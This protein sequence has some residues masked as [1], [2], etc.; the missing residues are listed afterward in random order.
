MRALG[1][2]REPEFSPGK[3]DAD[4]AILDA[5]LAQLANRGW[6]TSSTDPKKLLATELPGRAD[7]VLAMCQSQTA[8]EALQRIEKSGVVVINA[9]D[10]IRNCYRIALSQSLEAAGIPA[11]ESCSVLTHGVLDLSVGPSGVYVKRGDFHA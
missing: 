2:Y 4:A 6:Q 11:P 3:V 10:A 5:V 7:V 1:I 8:L 9:P